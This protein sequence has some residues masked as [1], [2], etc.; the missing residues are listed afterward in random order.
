MSM[1]CWPTPRPAEG[2]ETLLKS[3]ESVDI[4]VNNLGIYEAKP[5]GEISDADWMRFFE[6][7]VLSGVRLSRG[8][9]PGMLKRDWGRIIFVSS[10]S[11]VNTPSAMIH[12]AVTKAAQLSISRGLAELTKNTNVTVNAILPGPTRSEGIVDFLRSV[13]SNPGGTAE[14]LEAEFFAKGRPTSLIQRMIEPQEVAGMVAYLASPLAAATNGAALR[15]DGG[16]IQ[17]MA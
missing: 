16:L 11:A 15:V 3:V 9:F 4:L 6:T 5:F 8:Y 14:E 13:S 10:E 12:Y 17:T 2:A 1:A 7:N